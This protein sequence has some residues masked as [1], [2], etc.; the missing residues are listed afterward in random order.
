MNRSVRATAIFLPVLLAGLVSPV[1]SADPT[2]SPAGGST[3]G[4]LGMG[5][6]A[7]T[8]LLGPGE[9][10][11][12]ISVFNAG[13]AEETF[14]VSAF[15]FITNSSGVR[16]RSD[17]PVAAGAAA[18]ISF[19]R[20]VVTLAPQQSEVFSF[21][22][23]APPDAS[24]GDH[25]ASVEVSATLSDAA[26]GQ[27]KAQAGGGAILRSR[28]AQ[29][30]TV[31]LR[32]TGTVRNDLQA[33]LGSIPALDVVWDNSGYVL[34]PQIANGG[35]VTAIWIPA[36]SAPVAVDP[37]ATVPTLRLGSSLP[38]LASNEL[39]YERK[40]DGSPASVVAL[41]GATIVQKLTLVDV[42][43]FGDYDLTYTLPGN[44]A[45]G[46]ATV[47]ATAHITLI[48]MEKVLLYIV[49]PILVLLLLLGLRAWRKRQNR[50]YRAKVK[51]EAMQEARAALEREAAE[52][53][54]VGP[55]GPQGPEG[56]YSGGPRSGTIR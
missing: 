14:G 45:D 10:T 12:S 15:D 2:S 31:V 48:N 23:A 42:P 19:A 3:T 56:P 5:I 47:T 36:A 6:G 37:V 21:S 17:T 40:N 26:W 18:W 7:S 22:I 49:L 4:R 28:I 20:P 32:I 34:R 39:L 52:A 46:R 53:R 11:G 38:A 41:P 33:T 16:V 9:T 1:F 30:V 54:R 51:E 43:L 8:I 35:N 50:R 44:D 29:G 55:Q 24:P 13:D 27:A 25:Y